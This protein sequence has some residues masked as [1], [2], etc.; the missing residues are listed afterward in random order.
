MGMDTYISLA[1]LL[2]SKKK[3]LF[4][5]LQLFSENTHVLHVPEGF[6]IYKNYRR[7]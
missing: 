4:C 6:F 3:L 7:I 5:K 2:L 1:F